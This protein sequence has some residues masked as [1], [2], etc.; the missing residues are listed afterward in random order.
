MPHF[1]R[2]RS[3]RKVSTPV[4][5]ASIT[6]EPPDF[7]IQ[8]T[9]PAEPLPTLSWKSTSVHLSCSGSRLVRPTRVSLSNSFSSMVCAPFTLRR[10]CTTIGEVPVPGCFICM[11]W[12]KLVVAFSELGMYIE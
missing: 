9:E 7:R 5:D 10:D 8:R 3:A 4:L 6:V 1:G 12:V 11:M 2:T